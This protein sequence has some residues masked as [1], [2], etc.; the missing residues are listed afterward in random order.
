MMINLIYPVAALAMPRIKCSSTSCDKGTCEDTLGGAVCTCNPGFQLMAGNSAK[1]EGQMFITLNHGAD[2]MRRRDG[3]L[4]ISALLL[5][6]SM[7]ENI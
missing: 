5:C 4:V 6:C 1:C 7:E 2:R 3:P